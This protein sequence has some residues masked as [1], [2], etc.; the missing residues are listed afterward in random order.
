[1]PVLSRLSLW[2]PP[3]ALMGVIFFLSAQPDLSTDLGLLDTV[4]RK[5]VHAGEYALLSLL[6]WRALRTVATERVALLAALLI[7]VAYAVSDEVHQTFVPTRWGSP[8]DVAID[9]VGAGIAAVL[10]RRRTERSEPPARGAREDLS[11]AT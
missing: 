2:L 5:L 1:V 9:A 6:W 10:I 3:F 11:R 4:G 8:V 7:S